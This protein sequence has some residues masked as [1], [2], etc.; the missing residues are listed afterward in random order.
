MP[1]DETEDDNYEKDIISKLDEV[2]LD[3]NKVGWY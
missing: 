3:T 1:K 2:N